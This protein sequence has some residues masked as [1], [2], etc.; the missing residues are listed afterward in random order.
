MTAAERL[1]RQWAEVA[2]SRGGH[3]ARAA[4]IVGGHWVVAGVGGGNL[5]ESTDRP[6]TV[7]VVASHGAFGDLGFIARCEE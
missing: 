6:G 4:E 7:L 1:G 2:G 5:H 3:F